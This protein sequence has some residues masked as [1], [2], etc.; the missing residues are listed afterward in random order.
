MKLRT[1]RPT[2][3]EVL[4]VGTALA[5]IAAA[6]GLS[7]ILADDSAAA[8]AGSV[9]AVPADHFGNGRHEVLA[10]VMAGTYRTEGSTVP[11]WPMCHWQLFAGGHLVASGVATGPATIGVEPMLDAVETEYCRTWRR[12]G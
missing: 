1:I 11:D 6:I 12:Q 8:P 3:G 7:G 2:V 4:I 5:F 9:S 10:D